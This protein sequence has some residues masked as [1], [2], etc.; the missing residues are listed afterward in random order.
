[1]AQNGQQRRQ[2]HQARWKFNKKAACLQRDVGNLVL[3]KLLHISFA[4]RSSRAAVLLSLAAFLGLHVLLLRE[5]WAAPPCRVCLR[6]A[7]LALG[8]PHNPR[9]SARALHPLTTP[10][11]NYYLLQTHLGIFNNLGDRLC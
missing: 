10:K 4:E 3:A 1:M 8:W 9:A 7:A 6:V 5:S 11:F 2:R